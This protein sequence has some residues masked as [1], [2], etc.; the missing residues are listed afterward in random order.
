[1]SSTVGIEV[2]G[3]AELVSKIERLAD[4][5]DKRKEVILLLKNIAKP[6]LNVAKANAPVASKKVQSRGKFIQPGTLKKSLGYINVKSEN[7]TVAV[8]ARSK[9]NNDGWFAHFVH[10]GHDVYNNPNGASKRNGKAKSSLARITNKRKGNVQRRVEGN[11]F[12]NDAY[13]STKGT[14]TADAE[15]QMAAF[16]Q[17]RINKLS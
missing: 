9:G 1:M 12:L 6:T 2:K 16:I 3:F 14:V 13:E 4:D 7:P 5:K 17:R 10:A 11:P 8:G 15:K